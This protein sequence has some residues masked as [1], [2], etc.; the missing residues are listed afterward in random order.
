MLLQLMRARQATPADIACAC[1][2]SR[3][4]VYM[5]LNG[6][7]RITDTKIKQLAEYFG[8]T[9]A[10]MKFGSPPLDPD[11]LGELLI[12]ALHALVDEHIIATS[13]SPEQLGYF[14][15]QTCADAA[16]AGGRLDS[17]KIRR[18]I[19]LIDPGVSARSKQ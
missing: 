6:T 12:G 14:L 1:N 11:A 13:V 18:Y 8:V 19:K 10:Y 3:E 7:R 5:W 9:E 17:D 2:C 4:L 16:V 15:A